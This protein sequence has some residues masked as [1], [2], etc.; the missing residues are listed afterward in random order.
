MRCFDRSLSFNT[1]KT[2]KITQ[3]EYQD[4]Y[5]GPK[6]I[7]EV[8]YAQVLGTIFVTITFSSG[9]PALY[10]LNLAILFIQYWID[11]WLVLNYYKK[12]TEF[13]K[14]LS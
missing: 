9:M 6:F 2:L 10:A 5:T 4:L 8:R 7:L 14:H 12:T 1:K 3:S 11:K 13:T